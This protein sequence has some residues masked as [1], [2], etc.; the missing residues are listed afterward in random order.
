MASGEFKRQSRFDKAFD[1]INL[2]VLG[3]V[4]LIILYP[5]YFVIMNSGP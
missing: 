3:I 1:I 2:T 5:L 4:M